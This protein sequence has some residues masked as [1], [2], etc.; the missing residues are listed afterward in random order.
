MCMQFKVSAIFVL[1]ED[2]N[3][4]EK[5]QVFAIGPDGM[6]VKNDN[7]HITL[8]EDS[9]RKGIWPIDRKTKKATLFRDG[10]RYFCDHTHRNH[11]TYFVEV[12]DAAKFEVITQTEVPAREGET[13]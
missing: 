4:F 12:L 11:G 10:W 6:Y 3:H 8:G 5:Y 2:T 7:M 9:K 13:A 1:M